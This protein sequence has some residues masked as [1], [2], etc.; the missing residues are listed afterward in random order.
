MK[1][2]LLAT[3]IF[4]AEVVLFFVR[5]VK[6]Y[7]QGLWFLARHPIDFIDFLR[8]WQRFQRKLE[9]VDDVEAAVNI[10]EFHS[11]P[12]KQRRHVERTLAKA[13]RQLKDGHGQT[14]LR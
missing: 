7:A 10:S 9:D 11:L 5:I 4:S 13:Q 8:E 12:R 2:W 6:S 14:Q 3:L 1:D